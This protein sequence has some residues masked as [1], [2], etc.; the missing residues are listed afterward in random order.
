MAAGLRGL[1]GRW[2]PCLAVVPPRVERHS[3]SLP[4]AAG[5]YVLGA[6]A[7]GG[8]ALPAPLGWIPPA[9]KGIPMLQSRSLSRLLV[10]TLAAVA[11]VVAACGSSG[12]T[13]TSTDATTGTVAETAT[14]VAPDAGVSVTD[15]WARNSPMMA[16]DGAA[17]LVLRGGDTDDE[18][19]G[20]SV[21]TD[22]AASVELHETTTADGD[23]DDMDMD[24]MDGVHGGMGMMRMQEVD[25][26]AVPAGATVTLEP[27]G[28]HLMLIDL[29]TPLVAGESFPMTLTFS[30]GAE[31][32]VPVEVRS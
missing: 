29:A 13:D 15:A 26:I 17:Y 14:T 12:D 23:M 21:P 11:L 32:S 25:A 6:R 10:A 22:V 18:L 30:S 8:D 31:V 9:P 19:V 1:G 28:L 7:G 16:G 27:G 3:R 20:A 2:R 5:G 4:A 24:D